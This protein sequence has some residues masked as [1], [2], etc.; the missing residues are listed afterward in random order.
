M[1]QTKDK[2]WLNGYKN[3]T[4]TY[5]LVHLWSTTTYSTSPFSPFHFVWETDSSPPHTYT[6]II[7]THHAHII[8]I[9]THMNSFT[10]I[11]HTSYIHTHMNSFTHTS[12]THMHTL[13]HITHTHIMHTH[14][15]YIYI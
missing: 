9:H 13:T 4:P 15:I 1:P 2:D 14:H 5:V 6:H 7:Y 8:H 12:Y 3:K 10:H 11:S